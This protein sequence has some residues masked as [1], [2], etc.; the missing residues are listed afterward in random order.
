MINKIFISFSTLIS[1]ILIAAPVDLD[2][3][4]RVAGFIYAERSNTGM[5]DGFN[6]RTV[7]NIL[8]ENSANLIYDNKQIS[9]DNFV[10]MY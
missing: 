2:K 1:C 8:D 7:D 6:F 3:A 5:V 9:N 10:N 4:Q